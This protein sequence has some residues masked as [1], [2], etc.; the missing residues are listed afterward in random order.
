MENQDL[1]SSL[2]SLIQR[3]GWWVPA[4]D[5]VAL[6]IILREV[7]DLAEILPLCKDYRRVVQAGGNVGI[8]PKALSEKFRAVHTFEPDVDNY[9]ALIQN[10]AG[11]INILRTRGGL[12]DCF[13][14][15]AM[16][17]IDP[18][19]IGAHQIKDGNDFQIMPIDSFEY[20]DVDLIQLDIEGFEHF[21]MLGAE[22]TIDR[23]SPVIC[24][25]LK[26]LGKRYGVE[27]S[28][29][30]D[31]LAGLGYKISKRIHRDVIFTRA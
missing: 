20:D 15:G 23:C 6:D 4:K 3:R 8:W 27:D 12:G 9:A 24:L 28:E 5:Q 10:T 16:D 14:T 31:F 7:N 2:A 22:D 21:A 18:D 13:D 30:V 17:H 25:E 11:V 26:G 29:T 1:G 19:N